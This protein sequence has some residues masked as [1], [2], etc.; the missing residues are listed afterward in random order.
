MFGATVAG[1]VFGW[2]LRNNRSSFLATFQE[3]VICL[4]RLDGERVRRMNE[5]A[6][7]AAEFQESGDQRGFKAQLWT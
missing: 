4:V 6:T 7:V 3:T 2:R 1:S 5:D